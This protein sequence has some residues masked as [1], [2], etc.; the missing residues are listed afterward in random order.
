MYYNRFL[1]MLFAATVIAALTVTGCESAQP[2]PG[3]AGRY[4]PALNDN[5]EE[6]PRVKPDGLP[7]IKPDDRVAAI[8]EDVLG[9]LNEEKKTVR[10]GPRIGKIYQV[11]RKSGEI[12]VQ[13]VTPDI[14][15]G[16]RLYTRVQGKAVI[17]KAT[18][19]MQT[20]VKCRLEG[21]HGKY[22]ASLKISM[23]VH[24]YVQGVTDDISAAGQSIGDEREREYTLGRLNAIINDHLHEIRYG[25]LFIRDGML[26]NEYADGRKR[27]M[28]FHEIGNIDVTTRN[29]GFLVTV[30]CK[31]GS[32][33]LRT[34]WGEFNEMGFY[35]FTDRAVAENFAGIFRKLR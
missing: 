12:V 30:W 25:K 29:N 15:M 34:P 11:H 18:F 33:C 4:Q 7:D 14:R 20:V 27:E 24:K 19:P 21:Q 22:L 26:Y 9:T 3:N 13:S 10:E 28:P 6:K 32:K 35:T 16:S 8:R 5:G 1:N 17:M 23:P 31:S 2:Q